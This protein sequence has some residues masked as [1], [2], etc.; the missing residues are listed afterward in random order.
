MKYQCPICKV[1][2]VTERITEGNINIVKDIDHIDMVNEEFNAEDNNT[3]YV[4][5]HCD[6]HYMARTWGQLLEEMEGTGYGT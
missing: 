6:H 4:C 2:S 1:N 5:G 3:V